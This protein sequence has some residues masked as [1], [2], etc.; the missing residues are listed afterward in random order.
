MAKNLQILA[1]LRI[2]I[3]VP[4]QLAVWIPPSRSQSTVLCFTEKKNLGLASLNQNLDIPKGCKSLFFLTYLDI[5]LHLPPYQMA[6]LLPSWSESPSFSSERINQWKFIRFCFRWN[7]DFTKNATFQ[8]VS[9]LHLNFQVRFFFVG[10]DLISSNTVSISSFYFSE[11]ALFWENHNLNSFF[12]IL[13]VQ[14]WQIFG[15]SIDI[16]WSLR[17]VD[18]H[19]FSFNF[20]I[21]KMSTASFVWS[22]LLKKHSVCFRWKTF[23][24]PKPNCFACRQ[25]FLSQSIYFSTTCFNLSTDISLKH[26][27]QGEKLPKGTSSAMS[28]VSELW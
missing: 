5:K 7:A 8:E 4:Q 21:K 26:L 3:L 23:L 10:F 15:A 18:S 17:S 11:K 19:S 27:F 20:F 12:G 1:K 2:Q 9:R 22:A 28:F 6:F 25:S 13:A 24:F 14:E 16:S